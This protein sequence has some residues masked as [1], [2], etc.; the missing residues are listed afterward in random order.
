MIIKSKGKEYELTFKARQMIR[1][2]DEIGSQ[3]EL[4]M[5]A[6]KGD[7]KVLGKIIS[8]FSDALTYDDALDAI[9]ELLE[10][11][12]SI[13]S[14]YADIFKEMNKKAFFTKKLEISEMPPINFQSFVEKVTADMGQGIASKTSEKALEN[15]SNDSNK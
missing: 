11:G 6:Y 9:D 14:I 2:G 13:K 3:Y 5:G 12:G 15:M 10:N 7:M 1:C 4:E 8:I